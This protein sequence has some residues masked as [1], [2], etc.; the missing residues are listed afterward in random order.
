MV[1]ISTISSVWT[2]Y[3]AFLV[4]SMG[5][6]GASH[7]V[8]WSVAVA[9]WFRRL[10][11][12]ALGIAMLG[13][14]V[15]GPFVVVVGLLE[16]TV[17]WRTAIMVLGIGVWIVGIPLS[18]VARSDPASYGDFPDGDVPDDAEAD[19][20]TNANNALGG[21]ATGLTVRQALATRDFWVFTLLFA[22]QFIGISGLMV[23]LIPLLEDAKYTTSQAAGFLGL[24]FLF[25]GIGRVGAGFL[26]DM[27]DRRLVLFGLILS[28]IVALMVLTRIGPLAYFQVGGFALLLGIGFGGMIP[29]RPFL[30]MQAFGPRAFGAIQGLVQGAAIAAGVVGP[31]GYGYIFDVVGSYNVA[32]FATVAVMVAAMPLVFLFSPTRT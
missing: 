14:V 5:M 22:A 17:G 11:G 32:I 4:A 21:G 18:L 19:T 24:V 20:G 15:A 7:G 29:L 28:Q 6:S 16:E 25:S 31:I 23:H 27:V 26:V 10:R 2:F 30:L 3:L 1:L 9:K 8:S 13:P 12:R